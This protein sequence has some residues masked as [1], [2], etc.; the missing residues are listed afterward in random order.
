MG[1]PIAEIAMLSDFGFS[2]ASLMMSAMSLPGKP[3]LATSSILVCTTIDTGV[4][5]R[6]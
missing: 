5:S 6:S 3:G 1:V 2:F 4:R